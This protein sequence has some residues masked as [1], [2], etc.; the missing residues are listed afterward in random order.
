MAH[1]YQMLQSLTWFGGFS[2][3][4]FSE[5]LV[6]DGWEWS[7]EFH[8]L[9]EAGVPYEEAYPM[10]IDRIE[11]DTGKEFNPMEY[12]PFHSSATTK[13]TF[14]V[15]EATAEANEWLVNNRA[16][17]EDYGLSASFF[18]PRKV[19]SSDDRYSSEAKQ[20]AV[21]YGLRDYKTPATFLSELYY[22]ASYP[23]YHLRRVSHL[24]RKYALTAAG[25]PSTNED[26]KWT[27]WFDMWSN[28]N[29]VF[30]SR[31]SGS[32]AQDRRDATLEEFRRLLAVPSLIPDG[33]HTEDLKEAM[34]T[35]V[36]LDSLYARLKNDR[37]ASAQRQRD[38]L[39]YLSYKFM[40]RFIQGRPWL[41]EMYYSVFLPQLGD[42]WL[43]KLQAGVID[44]PRLAA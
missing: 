22:Q 44:V 26:R 14:G 7:N 27:V 11:K 13:R 10:W 34:R 29:P 1:Q 33:L 32:D 19:D 24:A 28:R 38:S 39:K 23:E 21:N 41:N 35:I 17:V 37:T 16:F 6:H 8:E 20:R 40:E 36:E 4:S 9:L 5:L 3:G 43:A 31:I 25:L 30:S 2:T 42:T 18:M 15:L 12:S